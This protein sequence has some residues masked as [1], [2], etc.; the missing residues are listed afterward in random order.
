TRIED[1]GA[2]LAACAISAPVYLFAC[3][4]A[5]VWRSRVSS[6]ELHSLRFVIPLWL[7]VGGVVWLLASGAFALG[8]FALA[9]LV[10]VALAQ[11]ASVLNF[12]RAR[13]TPERMLFRKR[14]A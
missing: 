6:P 8:P 9:G 11:I 7:V 3:T 10:F 5:Y 14:L 2:A 1:A 12:A 13:Y 4:Q